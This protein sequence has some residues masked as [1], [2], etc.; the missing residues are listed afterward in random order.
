MITSFIPFFLLFDWERCF[1][2]FRW[3]YYLLRKGQELRNVQLVHIISIKIET[4]C[5][6]VQLTLRE[7]IPLHE[8]AGTHFQDPHLE[9]VL[10]FSLAIVLLKKSPV[11]FFNPSSC[12][13]NVKLS[14]SGRTLMKF[15]SIIDAKDDVIWYFNVLKWTEMTVDYVKV[16]PRE[17]CSSKCF[18]SIKR[19]LGRNKQV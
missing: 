1:L 15:S 7:F 14:Y 3:S 2:D 12:E 18:Q 13:E 9:V 17:D 19:K 8:F 5:F 10:C 16:T 4:A 11:L 6:H